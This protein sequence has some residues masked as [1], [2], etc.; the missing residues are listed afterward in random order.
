MKH[1]LRITF[2]LLF[3]F[4]ITQF[5]GIYVVSNYSPVKLVDNEI[6]DVESPNLPFGLETPELE[7]DEFSYAFVSIVIAFIIAISFLFFL[8]KFKIEFFI[9]AWF[10]L[11]VI[12]ALVISFNVFYP[13][14][15]NYA[16]VT[17]RVPYRF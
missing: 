15:F 14:F 8:S 4:L 1:N 5:I 12:I 17:L 10:F 3:M 6:I 11:V 2:I 7:E 16:C 13:L 9:K